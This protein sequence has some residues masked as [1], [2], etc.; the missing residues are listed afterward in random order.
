MS[1]FSV[2]T[3][4]SAYAALASLAQTQT[5]L[6][7]T[8]Q[9]IA[10]GKKVSSAADNPAIYAISNTMNAQIAGLS[11]VQDGLSFSGQVVGTATAATT[12]ISSALSTLKNTVTQAQ[13]QGL[14]QAQMNQS[15]N[16][17][18]SQ[19]DTFANSATMNGVNLLAGATGN[20]VSSTQLKVMTDAQGKQITVGGTG[21]GNAINATAAGLGLY[22][23][24][25]TS[26]GL[27]LNMNSI[28]PYNIS[29]NGPV[30][31]TVTLQNTMFGD[32]SA[33]GQNP[34]QQWTFEFVQPGAAA[35]TVAA[36]DVTDGLGNVI[37]HQNVVPVPLPVGFTTADAMAALQTAM[38]G[39]GFGV[40]MNSDGTLNIIGNNLDTSAGGGPSGA[41]TLAAVNTGTMSVL[42]AKAIAPTLQL[43][44]QAGS[45][46]LVGQTIT[47]AQ[48][49][50]AG[51]TITS[52]N[53]TTVTL[54]QPTT[55]DIA[56]QTKLSLTSAPPATTGPVLAGANSVVL[57]SVAGLAAGQPILSP[58][59]TTIKS[60]DAATNT[61]TFATPT[62]GASTTAQD[63]PLGPVPA[64][65]GVTVLEPQ[66]VPSTQD[67]FPGGSQSVAFNANVNSLY[68]P[69]PTYYIYS[70]SADYAPVSPTPSSN[71]KWEYDQT[72]VANL[73]AVNAV[74]GIMGNQPDVSL[75][76]N[77]TY[78][79]WS[80]PDGVV[81]VPLQTGS[82]TLR[83]TSVQGLAIGQQLTDTSMY[84]STSPPYSTNT[85]S[86]TAFNA[87]IVAIDGATNQVTLAI[88]IQSPAQAGTNVATSI[89]A[90]STLP[91]GVPALTSSAWT[92][93][94]ATIAS[95]DNAIT[96]L[97]NAQTKLGTASDSITGLSSFNQS[98]SS[99]MT[100][101]VGALTDADMASA[102]AR[103]A[104]LQT[105]QQLSMQSLSIANQQPAVLLKLFGSH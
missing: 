100:A 27:V 20:G 103:L 38:Q 32:A 40:T 21:P 4:L 63:L 95:I 50:P 93:P 22:G 12:S 69:P 67:A 84:I 54:S 82:T 98:L 25:A 99:A 35:T 10:T 65:T 13:Q 34:G 87:Q 24:N 81:P 61:V 52:V 92:G 23:F 73:S 36:P 47:G 76:N 8:Q 97:G 78:A 60:I 88:P 53:G 79:S 91:T 74:P 85:T 64:F 57:S 55:A 18:L 101:S 58:F 68:G 105:K 41:I 51:T 7:T 11:A 62:V 15:I 59:E 39:A 14:S 30:N 71:D 56:A 16:G 17:L 66:E 37:Q 1:L 6:V 29:N 86:G 19:I 89:G 5:A 46:P 9:Q 77:G 96:Q 49:I 2:N 45:T 72:A 70:Q 80:N 33:T 75:F 102:S 104:S 42:P 83:L 28:S 31:T 43:T 3:N 94:Q 48:G 26:G 90:V 44:L